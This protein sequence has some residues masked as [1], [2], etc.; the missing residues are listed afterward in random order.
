MGCGHFCLWDREEQKAIFGRDRFG[1]KPLFYSELDGGNLVFASGNESYLSFLKS[2]E[3][4]EKINLFLQKYF[5]LR[6]H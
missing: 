4:S 5:R 1:K 2:V 3:P 6:E